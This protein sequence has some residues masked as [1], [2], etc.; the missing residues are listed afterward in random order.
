M[1]RQLLLILG[2]SF[3][4]AADAPGDAVTAKKVQDFLQT[5]NNAYIKKDLDT[6][7]RLMTDDHLAILASGVRQT[8]AEHLKTL[9]DL[10]L[11]EYTMHEVK[12]TQPAKGV[13]IVTYRGS[14]KGTYKGKELPASVMVT[15]TW[16]DRNG[17]WAEVL[18]QETP[19]A[20]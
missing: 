19:I 18:Y 9:P 20:K 8:K 12:T 3:L 7:K 13:V 17:Q 1:K 10:Q 11:T 4:I 5:L 16:V 2:V 6:M 15:S 14:I